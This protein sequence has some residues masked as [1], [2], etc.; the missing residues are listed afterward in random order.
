VL[1]RSPAHLPGGH[2]HLVGNLRDVRLEHQSL[3]DLRSQIKLYK[4]DFFFDGKRWTVLVRNTD[5]VE[6]RLGLAV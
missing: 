4:S 5:L 3:F 2:D 6:H 1:G